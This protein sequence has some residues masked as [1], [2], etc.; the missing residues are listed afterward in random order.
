MPVPIV[1]L[2]AR[3]RQW[4]ASFSRCCS[5]PHYQHFV[6][7][8]VGVLLCQETRTLA[9]LRRQGAG[10]PS[11]ASL[12]RFLA[13][14]PWE[15]AAV[16]RTW[17]ARFQTQVAPLVQAERARQR[18]T[19]PRQ[20]GR[21]KEPL[22]TGYLIGDDSTLAKP[23]GTKMEGVGHPYS[24]T[25]AARVQGHSLVQGL[26]LLLGRRCPL[27]PLLYQQ[28]SLCVTR[29]TPF[30]SKI[31]LMDEHIRTFEPVAG[32]GTPVLLDRW[33]GAK[34]LWKAARERGFLITTGLKS[35]RSLRVPDPDAGR[36]WRWQ[37]RAEYAAGLTAPDDTL[38]DWPR[39]GE[40][41][42]E[43][44]QVY[45]QV[46]STRVRRLYCCQVVI[47]RPT[48]D[49][50]ASATRY[51]ASSDRDADPVTLLGH[52]AARWE[53]EVFFSDAKDLLGLDH[54]QLM[55]TTA[56]VRF[57]TLT[58]AA[59]TLL[60]EERARLVQEQ[61]RH[62]TLGETRRAL[63]HLHYRHLLGWIAHHLHVGVDADTLY[64]RLAA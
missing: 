6:T 29:A 3:V 52:I 19:Q 9:G 21:P 24:S 53:V 45:V 30:R 41:A 20:V 51:W 31:D 54:D 18:Q 60:E 42:E 26:Y 17:L 55:T 25:A 27:A 47:T 58:L 64:D 23:K 46:V 7:V 33:Y 38:M 61:Q 57:W 4:A 49:A 37:Q 12:S 40:D 22:V 8:L 13:R 56:I 28:E 39:P 2:D 35:N 34:R 50:P 59:Y 44:R 11:L 36:G 48:L 16:V 10:G 43:P 1:C 15:E 32:T 5:K 14:A 63:Q 62:L